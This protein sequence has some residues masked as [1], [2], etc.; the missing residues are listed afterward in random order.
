LKGPA[1]LHDLNGFFALAIHDAETDT[2]FVARD[3]FGV[4]PLLWSEAMAAS[5]SPANCALARPWVPHAPIPTRFL[6]QYFTYHYVPRPHILH[7]HAHKLLPGHSLH[8][9]ATRREA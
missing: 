5:F 9:D 4:K 1:F 8:V 2:L 6:E 3:R 7:R